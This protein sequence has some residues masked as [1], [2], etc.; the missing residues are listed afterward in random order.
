MSD[1]HPKRATK[2]WEVRAL[3]FSTNCEQIVITTGICNGVNSPV[4]ATLV[5]SSCICGICEAAVARRTRAWIET[6]SATP[7]GYPSARRPPYAG[8]DCFMP[9]T[10][11]K[12]VVD[13]VRISPL[14]TR[15][16]R[17][18]ITALHSSATCRR[19][20][21]SLVPVGGG[22][23][24]PSDSECGCFFITPADDL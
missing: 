2:P 18:T 8:V 17:A 11:R 24:G 6:T 4:R 10:V 5:V 14:A 16:N 19:R 23:V 21:D 13:S 3:A 12:R 1:A 7:P 20:R 22:L 9:R 15:V